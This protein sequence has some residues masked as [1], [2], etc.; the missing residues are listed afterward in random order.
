MLRF[1]DG[2]RNRSLAP[3][4]N[5]ARELMEL[6]T[7][8]PADVNGV[9]NYTQQ[10]VVQLARAVTGFHWENKKRKKVV[11]IPSRFDDGAKVMFAGKSF[12]A[13]GNLSVETLDGE[14]APAA[15]NVIDILFTHRDSD[16]RPTLARFIA[17]KLW[18]WFAYPDPALSLV[19]E[20]ADAF[21][22]SDYVIAELVG[23]I[24]THD[25]FY[26]QRAREETAKTPAD[27]V[28]QL[29]KALGVKADFGELADRLRFMGMDLFNPP[30]VNGWE[31]G[32]AWLG[33]S[34]YL[35]R[36]ALAQEI[37]RSRS[38]KPFRFD[39]E[40]KLF[41]PS[42]GDGAGTVDALLDL[43]HL[44]VP[45]ETRQTLIDYVDSGSELN[46]EDWLETKYRGLFVL[47]LSLPEFQVH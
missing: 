8:G 46:D 29:V 28:V 25:E 34:L 10:D 11:L 3:N 33:T 16:G 36:I 15:I 13:V 12:E 45:A 40:K 24:L 30:G 23:A 42:R 31:H 1:L 9:A 38:K 17:R 4:E 20:L 19:D 21:V 14:L 26:S 44:S 35:A 6:F 37:A 27:F 41:E 22:D 43:L 39:P 5:Y 18:E 7:L 32:D 2:I 47:L